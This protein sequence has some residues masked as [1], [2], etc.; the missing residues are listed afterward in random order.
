MHWQDNWDYLMAAVKG[1]SYYKL[2]KVFQWLSGNIGFHHI[3]H[4]SHLIP[5]YNLERCAKENPILQKYANIIT[6]RDSLKTISNKLWDEQNQKMIS[7]KEFYRRGL[8]K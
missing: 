4:L 1:S 7:F 2:P 3:H 5:N 6:F 8:E